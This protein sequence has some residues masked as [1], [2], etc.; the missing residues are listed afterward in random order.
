MPMP[1]SEKIGEEKMMEPSFE[2]LLVR[3]TEADVRFIVV[4]GIAV[5]LNGYVRLTED[6]DLLLESSETNV[7]R[8]L[9]CLSGFGEGYARELGLADFT[10]EEGAIRI[11]EETEDCQIDVFTIMTGLRHADLLDNAGTFR[12]GDSDI[13]FAAKAD[14]IRLKSSSVREKDQLDVMALKRLQEDPGCL[15]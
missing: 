13:R 2:K 12:I 1:F 6:I 3:L 14:L 8:F 15:D 9:R 5:A 4:G 11:V 7:G 10:E